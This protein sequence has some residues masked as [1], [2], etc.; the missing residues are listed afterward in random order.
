MKKVFM[1]LIFLFAFSLFF[2]SAPSLAYAE[3]VQSEEA[4]AVIEKTSTTEYFDENILPYITKYGVDVLAVASALL[5]VLRKLNKAKNTFET[6]NEALKA[7]KEQTEKS[8]DTLLMQRERELKTTA[9]KELK[10]GEAQ[11]KLLAQ[12]A[13]IVEMK[14]ALSALIKVCRIAFL[15]NKTLVSGGYAAKIAEIIGGSSDEER[16]K[17]EKKAESAN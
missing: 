7:S 17:V 5:L 12:N 6:A 16:E 13:E 2:I 14:E 9:E 15:N 8:Y 3:E 10:V 11:A 1:I 4:G